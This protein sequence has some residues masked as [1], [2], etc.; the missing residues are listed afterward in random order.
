MTCSDSNSVGYRAL[1]SRIARELGKASD[2]YCRCGARA[3]QWAYDHRD[4]HELVD[5]RCGPYSL[6]L[7]RY[8][9]MCRSCHVRLDLRN[10]RAARAARHLRISIRHMPRCTVCS[11][12]V[13]CGQGLTHYECR[14]RCPECGMPAQICTPGCPNAR[15]SRRW[16]PTAT[17]A[18]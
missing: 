15:Q 7:A 5:P 6:N 14:P 17:P 11:R 1:H 12:P 13:L 2:H 18:E 4:S 8:S 9:A 3:S 10:A 16:S